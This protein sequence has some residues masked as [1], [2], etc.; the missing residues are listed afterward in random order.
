MLS[1]VVKHML[2]KNIHTH[3]KFVEFKQF[4]SLFCV[5]TAPKTT[6]LAI[7]E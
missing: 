5:E 1:D 7:L 3:V 4:M 2:Q 6:T